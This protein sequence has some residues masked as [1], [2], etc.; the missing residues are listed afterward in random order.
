MRLVN[1][2]ILFLF[3]VAAAALAGEAE[4][5]HVGPQ[6]DG[7]ILVPTNQVLKPAGQQVTFAGRPVDLE[8]SADGK[9]LL[10]KNTGD[11]LFIDVEKAK[12]VATLPLGAKQIGET[13]TQGKIYEGMSIT[14]IGSSG[15]KIYAS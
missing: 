3:C 15:G 4:V 5:V 14:G 12:V 8:L 9:T 11:I 7:R 6:A 1:R 13:D 10:V 2:A